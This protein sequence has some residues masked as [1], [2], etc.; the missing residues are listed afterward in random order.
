MNRWVEVA[1]TG[2][3]ADRQ[4]SSHLKR[5]SQSDDQENDLHP[6]CSSRKLC[7]QGHD[8]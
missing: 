2:R 4:S 5:N 7:L 1:R 6:G 8:H 3:K